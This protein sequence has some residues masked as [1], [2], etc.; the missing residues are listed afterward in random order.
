MGTITELTPINRA[1]AEH[2]EKIAAAEERQAQAQAAR[3]AAAE[4]KR[5][6][7]IATLRKRIEYQY[8][9]QLTDDDIAQW[10]VKK[11]VSNYDMRWI[12][13]NGNL[14]LTANLTIE[15]VMVGGVEIA[16]SAYSRTGNWTKS[17]KDLVPALAFAQTGKFL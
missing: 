17:F 9:L 2:L 5:L 16:W 8:G 7:F 4:A 15:E 11:V 12:V 14:G 3:E 13:P 10:E 1:V 6:E